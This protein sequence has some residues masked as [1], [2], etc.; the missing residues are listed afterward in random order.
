MT[1]TY[2]HNDTLTMIHTTHNDIH[3]QKHRHTN[4]D[5]FLQIRHRQMNV[6]KHTQIHMQ[7]NDKIEKTHERTRTQTLTRTYKYVLTQHTRNHT[8]MQ[9]SYVLSRTLLIVEQT[10]T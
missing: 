1:H 3:K 10:H 4:R 2:K 8:K 7:T 6:Q 9:I 5:K